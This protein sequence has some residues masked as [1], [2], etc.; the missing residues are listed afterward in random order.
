[1]TVAVMLVIVQPIIIGFLAQ[2]YYRQIGV[3]W[4]IIALALTGSWIYMFDKPYI[5]K[6]IDTNAFTLSFF[7][8]IFSSTLVLIAL[9]SWPKKQT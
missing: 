6:P 5:A 8:V 1:M 3:I 7:A 2:Q 9:A 4:A